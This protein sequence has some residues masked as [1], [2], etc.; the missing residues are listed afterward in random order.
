MIFD[1]MEKVMNIEK[2]FAFVSVSRH[3]CDEV[4][5]GIGEL[6]YR[7]TVCCSYEEKETKWYFYFY[8]DDHTTATKIVEETLLQGYDN[9]R[10]K[11]VEE[12]KVVGIL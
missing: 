11:K 2:D 5:P 3:K 12:T 1:V 9:F 6:V 7:A 8:A 10:I 4:I